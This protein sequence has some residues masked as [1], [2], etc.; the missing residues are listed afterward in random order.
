MLTQY[1]ILKF[2]HNGTLLGSFK[3][4][5]D[6]FQPLHRACEFLFAVAYM[7]CT[8]IIYKYL[9]IVSSRFI[10][11]PIGRAENKVPLAN[12]PI[13]KLGFPYILIAVFTLSKNAKAY[14]VIP[15]LNKINIA[16]ININCESASVIVLTFLSGLNL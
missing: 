2:N 9:I 16:Q 3:T 8:E 7:Q 13:G 6:V 4:F 14:S 10:S 1:Q 12:A 11:S 5:Q 15:K